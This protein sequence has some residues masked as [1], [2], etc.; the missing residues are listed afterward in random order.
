MLSTFSLPAPY[1]TTTYS[2]GDI[3]FNPVDGQIYAVLNTVNATTNAVTAQQLARISPSSG[4][5]TLL[6][7]ATIT[8][9]DSFIGLF[10][11]NQGNVYGY[12]GVAGKLWRYSS[13]TGARVLVKDNLPTAS[14]NADGARC[15]NSPAISSLSERPQVLLVKRITAINSTA[16]TTVVDDPNDANDT[17]ANWP[18]SYL[19]GA[20][21][22]NN[23]KPGDVVEYTIY[24]LSTGGSNASNANLC[25][26]VPANTTFV[27]DTFT[28]GKGIQQASGTA[29]PVA[30]TNISDTDPGQ[31]YSAT[32]TP[33]V[34]CRIGQTVTNGNGTFTPTN[35]S[36]AVVV[37]LGT[38]P[39]KT[40][41]ASKYYG[42]LKFRAKVN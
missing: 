11:D 35:V 34:S 31:F 42:Y 27:P 7:T 20:I 38:V 1:N 32:E 3:A 14:N 16:I 19:K 28:T 21:S 5:V 30:L 25:D 9:L 4:S 36:G 15:Y 24:F 8:D 13:A 40:N 23:I 2:F 39:T 33:P 29:T 22:Q 17:N 26:L 18:S 6:G 37:N 12:Q 10:V 41:D